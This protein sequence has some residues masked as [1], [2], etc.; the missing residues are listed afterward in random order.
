MGKEWDSLSVANAFA[1]SI[2]RSLSPVWLMVV[3]NSVQDNASTDFSESQSAR[4]LTALCVEYSS[5]DRQAKLNLRTFS[6]QENVLTKPEALALS[7]ELC[8]NLTSVIENQPENVLYVANNTFT[9]KCP[10]SI[11]QELAL[12]LDTNSLC[13]DLKILHSLMEGQKT[14]D[15]IVVM[16]GKQSDS[17]FTSATN[18]DVRNVESTVLEKRYNVTTSSLIES[19]KTIR[20]ITSLRFVRN[21]MAMF[22]AIPGNIQL[23]SER[24]HYSWL[25]EVYRILKPGA[26]LLA[27]AGTRTYHRLVVA[28]EDAGF[29]IRDQLQW[30]YGSGF[31][32]S[33]D[34]SKAIDKMF[35][36]EREVV[37]THSGSG[38][39]R[40]NVVQGAQQ[41]FTHEWN[42][43]SNVPATEDAK[44]W[45]GWGTALKPANE[46]IVLA[47]KPLIGTVAENVLKHGTGGLNIDA[48]RIGTGT[49]K[50]VRIATSALPSN[51]K[52]GEGLNGS[53]AVE[54]STQGRWPA[55]VLFDEEVAALL[56][57]QSGV[58]KSGKLTGTEPSETTSE[59]YGKYN[60]RSTN[61]IGDTG[62]AS[63]FFYVAKA[64]K[65][66]RNAGLEG[67]PRK[68]M[69]TYN[70]S[71]DGSFRLNL[72]AQSGEQKREPR[73]N[74]HPTVKPIKLMQYLIKLI[75]PPAVHWC[76]N[77]NKNGHEKSKEKTSATPP[78]QTMRSNI[79]TSGQ[80]AETQVLLENLS[81]R[82]D[83]DIASEAMRVV[84]KDIF[85]SKSGQESTEILLS[86]LREQGGG[87][88]SPEWESDDRSKRL[89]TTLHAGAS[90]GEQAGHANGTSVD[91][92]QSS[93]ASTETDRSGSSY[94]RNQRRQSHRKSRSDA[95]KET[96]QTGQTEW[97][98]G[99]PLSALPSQDQTLHPCPT[100]GEALKTKPGCVLDPF[101]GSGS[102]GVAAKSLGF[103]FIGIEL[104][105]EYV[106]IAQKRIQAVG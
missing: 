82:V 46:P 18:L 4:N 67:M 51:G 63:R 59:I 69:N 19:Q 10:K 17:R 29:E 37:G 71:E 6:V 25:K 81:A 85:A 23:L 48:S 24:F 83:G 92:E 75:T 56:D 33:L 61:T 90:N 42:K 41:R 62:G 72:T 12:K 40:S 35:G 31:P 91:H 8:P 97:S 50:P 38:M 68:P 100:C 58:L 43:Y 98:D 70:F 28:A 5:I 99:D 78:V 9:G 52:Y 34:V 22:T 86:E 2:L 26:H 101:M 13:E 89:Q 74:H 47:R 105:Q 14:S 36:A 73:Q 93:R 106:E 27:F 54:D 20:W 7:K 30:I 1:E 60:K 84:Q 88:Q 16:N 21:A 103:E 76:E 55:N 45:Q 15:P 80:H 79:Q 49:P 32:K 57:E 94:Q 87:P 96:R 66:E 11:A 3:A 44:K 102:T 53:K 39:T 64:S 77:C 104:N 95:K 65:R